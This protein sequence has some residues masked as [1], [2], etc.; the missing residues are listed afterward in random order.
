MF[1]A[2][3][4]WWE[5]DV[6]DSASFDIGANASA[7][8]LSFPVAPGSI[9]SRGSSFGSADS[10]LM[11]RYVIL[12]KHIES[13]YRTERNERDRRPRRVVDM[14]GRGAK[15]RSCGGQKAF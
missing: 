9:P 4:I 10:C 15:W 8:R 7:K 3:I 1:F 12:H 5:M 11:T 14:I 2:G 6:V 13:R